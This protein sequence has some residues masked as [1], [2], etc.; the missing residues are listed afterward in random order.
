MD[1][2]GDGEAEPGRRIAKGEGPDAADDLLGALHRAHA[3]RLHRVANGDIAL[4]RER[5]QAQR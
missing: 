2:L 3:L 4:D 1:R 5:R